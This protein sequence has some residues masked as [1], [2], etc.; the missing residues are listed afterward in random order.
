M[1]GPFRHAARQ[2]LHIFPIHFITCFT[3]IVKQKVRKNEKIFPR[4]VSARANHQRPAA[5]GL[6]TGQEFFGAQRQIALQRVHHHAARTPQ[7]GQH[8]AVGIGQRRYRLTGGR[9]RPLEAAGAVATA[10]GQAGARLRTWAPPGMGAG[11]SEGA[12]RPAMAADMAIASFQNGWHRC[13]I[14]CPLPAHGTVSQN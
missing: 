13:S 8:Y 11:M 12:E 1:I 10:R 4:R 6:K 5:H 14:S 7:G 3:G 9:Y 2:N